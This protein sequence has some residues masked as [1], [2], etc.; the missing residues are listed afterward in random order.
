MSE[1]K[2]STPTFRLNELAA[3]HYG[4]PHVAIFDHKGLT[5]IVKRSNIGHFCGYVLVDEDHE[6]HGEIKDE[7]SVHGGVTYSGYASFVGFPS[8]LFE[9]LWA[10]GFD[11][12][13]YNDA[14]YFIKGAGINFKDIEY[15]DYDFMVTQVKLLADQMTTEEEDLSTFGEMV[16]HV[17]KADE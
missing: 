4:E 7:Y 6:D 10:I 14:D 16:N 12:G 1:F 11:A 17:F 3:P 5:C 2:R 8:S 9:N 15:R 13:H